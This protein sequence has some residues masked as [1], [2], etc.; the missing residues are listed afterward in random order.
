MMKAKRLA[1]VVPVL[2]L[3]AAGNLP[4]SQGDNLT[5][6]RKTTKLR[7]A[8]RSFAPTVADLA[9]GDR[10]AFEA[11]EGAWYNVKWK[12]LAGFVHETDVSVRGDVRLSGEGVRESYSA[13]EAAAARKGFNPQVEREYRQDN[14]SLEAAFK[15]LD[16]IQSRATSEAAVKSFLLEGGLG[17]EAVR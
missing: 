16:A 8:K 7:A 14:P 12:T 9:E 11:K 3:L 17:G 4:Q 10:L 1:L 5:V 2:L 15:A 13:S 6:T